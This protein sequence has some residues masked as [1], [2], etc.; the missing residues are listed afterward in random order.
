MLL[1]LII[2][3]LS[4]AT[5]AS[6]QE[7]SF[8][9]SVIIQL[10]RTIAAEA[11][12]TN[13]LPPAYQMP[14]ENGHNMVITNANA[15]ELLS[16]AIVVW[17]DTKA[18]PQALAVQIHDLAGPAFDPQYEPKRDG[19][20]F[21]VHYADIGLYAPFWLAKAE[22][23]GHKLISAWNFESG[24][25]LTAA[26]LLV[27]MAALIDEAT[28]KNEFQPAV[29]IPL[30][31]SPKSWLETGKPIVLAAP[32]PPKVE[33]VIMPSLTVSLN[34][35]ELADRGP[36][37]LG[38]GLPPFCGLIRIDVTGTGPVSK[39]RLMLKN[40]ELKTFDG[41]GPHTYLLNSLTLDDGVQTISVIAVDDREKTY[42]YIYSFTVM[43]GRAS[44]FTPAERE[45][46]PV[47]AAPA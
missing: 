14:M 40:A 6:A 9:G 19:L 27:A 13:Q 44:G 45:E 35:I 12:R 47:D 41:A 38:K 42:A 28:K 26:Q 16:R 5:P 37:V 34:G 7:L 15:F 23:P 30:V 31:R 43:N 21:A 32:P 3:L 36:I 11:R 39:V 22:A 33:V 25:R 29:V 2:G 18:L 1:L 20:T 8:R 4:A 17:K 46:R 24:Y 10:A